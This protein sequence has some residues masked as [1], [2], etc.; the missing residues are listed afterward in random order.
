MSG[1]DAGRLARLSRQERAQLFEQIRQRK[2]TR[3]PAADRIPRREPDA[4]PPPASFAQERL[5]FFDRLEPGSA[6]YNV[7]VALRIA[8][9]IERAVLAAVLGE[10]VRRHEVLR[11]TFEE[12]D[13]QPIQ[14]IA[15]PAPRGSSRLPLV[16]LAAL[17]AGRGG[18]AARRLAQEESERPF[19][20]RRGPLLRAVLLRARRNEHLL[21][22]TLHHIVA[23]G[24][25]MGV[26]V[27]EITALYPAALAGTPA[28]LPAL[29]IQYADFAQW[30]RRR[31]EGE[32]LDALLGYWRQRLAGL[33]PLELPADRAR[34]PVRSLEGAARTLVMAE[35]AARAA[36]ELARRGD[37]T[38]FM[39]LLAAWQSVLG[40]SAGPAGS[41][42][43]DDVAIG[44]PIAN[45]NRAEI[46]PLI[47]FFVNTLVLRG[48]LAGDPPFSAIVR[49]ARQAAMEAYAHQDLPFEHLLG[50]L[51]RDAAPAGQPLFQVMLSLQNAPL[52]DMELPGLRLA[53]VE[54]AITTSRFDLEVTCSE[55]AAGLAVEV[56]YATSLFDAATALR[57]PRHVEALLRGAVEHPA[58]RLSELPLLLPSESQQTLR[59]WNDAPPLREPPAA[60]VHEIFAAQARATPDA[61]ALVAPEESLSYAELAARC[62]AL[63]RLLRQRGVGPE[64]PVGLCFDRSA[65]MVVAILAVLTAGGA[66]VPLDPELPAERFEYF[67]ADSGVRLL[68]TRRAVLAALPAAAVE[69]RPAAWLCIDDAAPAGPSG[70]GDSN[71]PNDPNDSGYQAG[72]RP[73]NLAYVLYT[74]GSTGRP[75]GT[76]VSHR[77]I[78]HLLWAMRDA[79]YDHCAAE[80]DTAGAGRPLRVGLTS[81]WIFDGAVEEMLHLLFGDT[82]V[83]L[84]E[85]VR[86]SGEA[87]VELLRGQRLDI[88]DATPAQ[89]KEWLGAGLLAVPGV[90]PRHILVGGE[91]LD[92]ITWAALAAAPRTVTWNL[93]G[94]TE[95]TVNVTACRVEGERVMLGRPLPRLRAYVLDR[96]LEPRPAGFVGELCVA[97]AGVTRGYL[98]RPDLTA[99]RFVPD[100]WSGRP[101]GRLYRTGDLARTLADGRLELRGRTDRQ[102][103]LRGLRIEPGEIEAALAALDGVLGAAVE[104]EEGATGRRLVAWVAGDVNPAELRRGARAKLPQG[105]VPASF[106][107][108]PRLP[109][110]PQGKV[111]RQA[112]P[113]TPPAPR[114]AGPGGEPA[115]TPET[116]G[117][118]GPAAPR[119]PLERLLVDTVA[120]VLGVERALLHDN[121]FELGGHSLLATRLVSRLR[122][123]HGLP[124]TLRMVFD[125]ADLGELAERLAAAGQPE[126]ARPLAASLPP[127]LTR[128]PVD[129]DPIPAS[130][131]QERLW[132]MDRLAPGT[133][134]YNMAVALRIEGQAGRER[135]TL[136][137]ALAAVLGEV[138]RRHEALRTTLR[139][140]GGRPV[141][142]IAPPPAPGAYRLPVIDLA[143]LAPPRRAAEERRVAQ[144]E[145]ALPFD[146]ARG[147]LLRARLLRGGDQEH[148]LVLN[149]HHV[150]SDGWS[151]GVLVAE[152]GALWQA[153]SP[154]MGAAGAATVGESSGS[155]A[156]GGSRGGTTGAAGATGT[157]GSAGGRLP[158]L[159]VQY[160]D[161]A[162]WQRG[163]LQGEALE[164]QLS[165]WRGQLAGA[166]AALALPADRPRSPAPSYRGA[167][168][169]ARFGRPLAARLRQLALAG[170]ATPYMVL[171]AG[172]QALLGR[173]AGRQDVVVGS[174][175]ANRQRAEI[176][177]LIG[178][179]VNNLVLR[180]NLA[181]DPSFGE[182]LRRCRQTTLDA[183]AHQDLPFE[184]LVEA[185][186][187]PRHLAL[188]P[189]FQV[190][191]AMQNAPL[192]S[193]ELAGLRLQPFELTATT[194]R[195]DLEVHAWEEDDAMALLLP[196]STD[197]FDETTVRRL[198]THLEVLLD[199]AAAD[200]GR[201]LSALPLVPPGDSR[202]VLQAR[203]DGLAAPPPPAAVRLTRTPPRTAVEA[204][205]AALW[206]EL[207]GVGEGVVEDHFFALG[208]HSLLATQL[209]YRLREA[210]ALV[211]PLRWIFELPVLEDLAAALAATVAIGARRD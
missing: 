145:A 91:A 38:L 16:D 163:W 13:G 33:Q 52:E 54:L 169:T 31:L 127:P 204:L 148:V 137:A 67:I 201:P 165:Y 139:D 60:C 175:I 142:V 184:R 94:P 158:A 168:L 108:L 197:L 2:E 200:P 185:L 171:L 112:L 76:M 97:G 75:K 122:Q 170:N 35:P 14:V 8:G 172:L 209:V 93:Y 30:Q 190:V 73:D 40:R 5:W 155:A 136:A 114:P 92:P 111:D 211:L 144:Q 135:S 130:F 113:R 187:P 90:A 11:T 85:E 28:A 161:F 167:H 115:E 120:E 189:L 61:P 4:G 141:Q 160:A 166:P 81:S 68:L 53:P 143:A 86:S 25:S 124:L 32:T 101:G 157:T 24:W 62:A 72:T 109:L 196:Y 9:W 180:G 15:A 20:L 69:R 138:V 83:V 132:F 41:A 205:L 19:D 103:K 153:A 106:V 42:A 129:L 21:L 156:A 66:F 47:G 34:P 46:E 206:Q 63:A 199:A 84:P 208:G 87:M 100:P 29:P 154:A 152:I 99:E 105:L 118:D 192:G 6:A 123:R 98:G 107:I 59:E 188:T 182:W 79:V 147:P 193:V 119:T 56:A 78:V 71:D 48:D 159:A 110:T 1:A 146:L 23:D 43:Q 183:Y 174:P 178:F 210:H 164:S 140:A 27:R 10:V 104:V 18:A 44:T 149:L 173:L 64:T 125:A 88:L 116:A 22:L 102:I 131:A 65:H 37:A 126:G 82:V 55:T 50:G 191:C 45:R 80:P 57:L 203:G 202:Q 74:S 39:V 26:L 96:R 117:H 162:V 51:R 194:A 58:R 12:R 186:R 89:L 177:P 7:P 36:H 179:F 151:I 77:A 176:E 133:A 195:Y 3:G 49:R 150:V 128:R 134:A 207:L 95:C 17:P 198:V 181:G 121:F 70:R